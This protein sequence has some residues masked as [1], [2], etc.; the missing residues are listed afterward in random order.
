MSDIGRTSQIL[1]AIGRHPTLLN[2]GVLGGF[3]SSLAR[4]APFR[5]MLGNVLAPVRRLHAIAQ[6]ATRRQRMFEAAGWLPHYTTPFD[7]LDELEAEADAGDLLDGHYRASWIEVRRQFARHIESYEID[8]EGRAVFAEALDCHEAGAYRAVSRLLFPDIERLATAAFPEAVGRP[9]GP[10]RAL[11]EYAA[12]LYLDQ[13]EPGGVEGYELFRR[14]DEHLYAQVHTP[15]EIERARRDSVPMRHAALHG[16][17]PYD[18]FRN[19]LN[20]VIMTDYVLQVI[21]IRNLERGAGDGAGVSDDD[22]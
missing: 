19:S 21:S 17:V 10:V 11:R 1:A 15:E 4:T 8:Q 22:R 3:T 2:V 20:A 5:N 7:A 18:T 13:T 12:E 16:K 9:G 6:R 14:L